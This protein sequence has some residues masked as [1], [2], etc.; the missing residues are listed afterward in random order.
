MPMFMAYDRDV[1]RKH[2]SG[3]FHEFLE[4]VAR[5]PVMLA[6]LNNASSRASPAN[7]N[8]ARELFELHTLGRDNYLNHLYNRWR[9]VPGATEGSRPGISIR[10]FTRPPGRL[11]DGRLPMALTVNAAT[12]FRIPAQFHY[13]DGWH[14]NYQKR[15]LG[16]E[17]DPEPVAAGRWPARA[18]P[19]RRPPRHRPASLRQALPPA[20]GRFSAAV[21]DR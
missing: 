17:F 10:M 14:D 4:A 19:G 2:C 8:F 3:N 1:I 12:T 21:T 11:P 6:Y 16:V 15:V 18:G 13:Y 9:D 5:S 7:E 20:R